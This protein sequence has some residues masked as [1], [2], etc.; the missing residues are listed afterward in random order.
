MWVMALLTLWRGDRQAAR[1]LLEDLVSLVREADDAERLT[2]AL[3]AVGHLERDDG[4]YDR[5]RAVYQESLILRREVGNQFALAQSLED[6]AV[7]AGREQQHDRA[8]RLL[9][10]AEPICETLGAS[11]PVTDATDYQRTLAEGRAALGEA[12]FATAWAEGRALSLEQ[13]I[14]YALETRC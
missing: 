12:R 1:P 10:A 4:N 6:F 14:A 9:G 7:L 2:H 13:A 11:T 5:A 3:G 8:V